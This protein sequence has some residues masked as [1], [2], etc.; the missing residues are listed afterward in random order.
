M[1]VS[2]ADVDEKDSRRCAVPI[3]EQ[4]C[5]DFETVEHFTNN[6]NQEQPGSPIRQ[7]EYEIN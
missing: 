2:V 5:F 4:E 7:K 3:L 6:E 1:G